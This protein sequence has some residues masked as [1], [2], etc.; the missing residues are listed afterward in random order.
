MNFASRQCNNIIVIMNQDKKYVCDFI[1]KTLTTYTFDR[2]RDHQSDNNFLDYNDFM[3]YQFKCVINL[4]DNKSNQ[5]AYLCSMI[6]ND[7]IC[8]CDEESCIEFT[9]YTIYWQRVF[10]E[11]GNVDKNKSKLT[12]MNPR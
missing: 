2:M 8:L 3:E 1:R 7:E 5:I 10:D 9:A 6:K 11:D 4:D 12:I